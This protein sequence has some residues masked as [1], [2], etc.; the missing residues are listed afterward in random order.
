MQRHF[1]KE[2]QEYMD[3]VKGVPFLY[4]FEPQKKHM[5][6]YSMEPEAHAAA[7]SECLRQW[8]RGVFREP[9]PGE[10]ITIIHPCFA[11]PQGDKHRFVVDCAVGVNLGMPHIAFTM[12]KTLD[13]CGWLKPG[14]WLGKEDC[15]DAFFNL[16]IPPEAQHMFGIAV[17]K[18]RGESGPSVLVAQRLIFGWSHS[19]LWY[20][21]FGKELEQR[22]RDSG[23]NCEVSYRVKA[24]S[25]EGEL[26][27]EWKSATPQFKSI[28]EGHPFNVT[29]FVDDYMF[30]ELGDGIL[31]AE[32]RLDAAMACFESICLD[33]NILYSLR[34]REKGQVLE[35]LGLE[36]DTRPS[37]WVL[38]V[39]QDKQVSIKKLLDSFISEHGA[40]PDRGVAP[41]TLAS[42]LGKLEFISVCVPGGPLFMMRIYA[43]FKGVII[44]WSHNAIKFA[45][46]YQ[47]IVIPE[48]AWKD[49]RWWQGRFT[50]TE[51]CRPITWD[52]IATLKTHGSTDASRLFGQ[53]TVINI[54]GVDEE[55][56]CLWDSWESMQGMCFLELVVVSILHPVPAELCRLPAWAHSRD[57]TLSYFGD[58]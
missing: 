46:S 30:G 3:P 45:D 10:E 23:Y 19:P 27:G 41:K 16:C 37:H 35:F 29:S 20:C 2:I 7:R 54:N 58:P 53:G 49:F 47:P 48:E 28:A 22:V 36:W 17:P 4:R 42:V 13:P 32:E 24:T 44:S 6:C 15:A 9:Y 56:A 51:M 21:Q 52:L 1:S 34:K 43:L 50:T 12:C 57:Q 33:C 14:M 11:V 5:K 40:H 26:L 25:K 8:S 55:S 18:A 38:R 31:S 39:P